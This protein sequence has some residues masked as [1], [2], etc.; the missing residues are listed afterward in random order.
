[1]AD[2]DRAGQVFGIGV[3]ALG[4]AHIGGR[5]GQV[6]NVEG[7]EVRNEDLAGVDVIHRDVEEA[8]DLVGVQVARH[9]AVHSGGPQQIGHQFGADRYTG[10]VFAVLAG[11]A[12]IGDDG[13]DLVSRCAFGGIDHQQQ[14]HQVVG[15]RKGGLD[16]EAGGSPYT[17]GIGRLEFTVAETGDF[18]QSEVNGS[19]FRTADSVKLINDLARK[20]P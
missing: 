1:M 9:H 20:V 13:N 17:F 12:E 15:G 5:D 3:G 2:D 8:L 14:F 19:F 18:R 4:T 7:F 10:F 6:V 11:P 16:E